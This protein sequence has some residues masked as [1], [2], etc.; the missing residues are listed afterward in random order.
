MGKSKKAS[1]KNPPGVRDH[2]YEKKHWT[3]LASYDDQ[4]TAREAAIDW[5]TK[6][7]DGV[8]LATGTGLAPNVVTGKKQLFDLGF[9]IEEFMEREIG[10]IPVRRTDGLYML[11]NSG[12]WSHGDIK[13]T[14]GT[15]GS[16]LIVY[17]GEGDDGETYEVTLVDMINEIVHRR[18]A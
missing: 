4:D 15:T 12:D 16:S 18:T 10:T 8:L 9:Q 14:C 7:D 17:L 11:S 5:S 13:G 2:I 1:K 3:L 6:V